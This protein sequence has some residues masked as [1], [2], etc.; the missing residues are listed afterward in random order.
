[1]A[2]PETARAEAIANALNASTDLTSAI[3]QVLPDAAGLTRL[4]DAYGRLLRWVVTAR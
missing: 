4:S 1:M 3:Y 2:A